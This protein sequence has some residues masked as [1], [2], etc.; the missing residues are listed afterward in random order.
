MVSKPTTVA[1]SSHP[2]QHNGPDCDKSNAAPQDHLEQPEARE[3]LRNLE[4]IERNDEDDHCAKPAAQS[5]HDMNPSGNAA[6]KVIAVLT[7]SA[8]KI[9]RTDK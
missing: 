4:D 9:E 6:M 7:D 2:S 8:N 3:F 5:L 1:H